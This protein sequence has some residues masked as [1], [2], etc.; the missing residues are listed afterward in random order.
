MTNAE[1]ILRFI[2]KAG[3]AGRTF[4]EI[5][6][7]IVVDMCKFYGDR[8]KFRDRYK[9]NKSSYRGYYGTNL[10][11]CM[12][13]PGLLPK[14]CEKRNGNWVLT[15]VIEGPFYSDSHFPT[16]KSIE[17]SFKEAMVGGEQ[18]PSIKELEDTVKTLK[19]EINILKQEYI[20]KKYRKDL[21][22]EIKMLSNRK[23][24]WHKKLN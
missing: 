17:K 5:N 22:A 10:Y 1:K 18:E 9:T 8:E 19:S 23:S 2:G 12:T 4:S 20:D 11:G 3:K 15:R 14:Y 13:K 24:E 6:E 16:Y 21:V 7:F